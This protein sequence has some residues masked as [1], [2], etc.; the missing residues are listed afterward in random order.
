MTTV[1]THYAIVARDGP[2][3]E[4]R[5]MAVR[6]AHFAHVERHLDRIAV[7]GPLKDAAGGF[8]G[9]ILVVAAASEA[10]ARAMLEADPYW[11]AGVW[12]DVT[13]EPFVPAA[14][15]WIGGTIW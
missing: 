5:R 11:I 3:A 14:G 2:G 1:V 6:D 10:E 15:T 8:T 12:A 7:A 13:I 4:P 9:S